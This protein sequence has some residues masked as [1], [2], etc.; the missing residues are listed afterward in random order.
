MLY[1]VNH[2]RLFVQDQGQ[3]EPALVFLHFYGGSSRTWQPVMDQLQT[4]YRCL[5]YDHR[6]W[7]QSDKPATG[8][9]IPELAADALALLAQ[10]DLG[11]YVLVG[12]SMGGKVAQLLASQRPAGLRG[13]VLV[14][15]S[16]ATPTHLPEPAFQALLHA[17]DT[18]ANAQAA[19]THVLTH[20]P[21]PAAVQQRT[22]NDMQRQVEASRVGWPTIAMPQDVSANLARI[23]VPV[24]LI[25]SEYDQVDPVAHLQAE[26]L[27]RLPGAQFVVVPNAG[28]LVM[29]E[30]PTDV[31]HLLDTFV[32]RLG[33]H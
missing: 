27:P 33:L 7:G 6:G 12:H 3:G 26:L 23:N 29:L 28:H 8:Y 10:L 19:L 22:L 16:P 2:T 13:L 25:A 31:A 5:A 30:A 1:A 18:P 20:R 24:L 4:R 17:Y 11:S 32:Q 15:P 9:G 14:A 21:L